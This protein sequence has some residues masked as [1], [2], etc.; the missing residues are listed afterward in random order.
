MKTLYVNRPWLPDRKELYA[1]FDDIL[2]T[3][4]LTNN[5][6]YVQL[7]EKKMVEFANV[8]YSY[9]TGNGTIALQIAIRALNIN[10]G[11]I[12]TTPHSFIASASSIVWQNCRPVFVDVEPD[13]LCINADLIKEKINTKT[14]AILAVHV[15]GS[16]CD[17]E[18]IN[19]IAAQH[20]LPVIYDASHAFGAAYKGESVFRFGT[21]S[22]A[23]LHA[24]KIVSAVE[25]GVVFCNEQQLAER[26]FKI[27]YFGKNEN[28]EE[29]IVGI[30]GKMDEFNA[31]FGVLSLDN[32]Q[33]ELE[34]RRKIASFYIQQLAS[35]DNVTLLSYKRNSAVNYSYFPLI[36]SGE[37]DLFRL[38]EAGKK[39][40]VLFKRIWYP[41]LNTL[42][43]L[44]APAA[45]L[46]VSDSISKRIVCVP[47]YSDMTKDDCQR[48]A[49]VVQ[50]VFT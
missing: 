28:N 27:R 41:S 19:R 35:L 8:P 40:Q 30:N 42:T 44:D 46:P 26:V 21:I 48:V 43:F 15:Y 39:Q 50:S 49:Q 37:E 33:Q 7:L 10:E 31:A 16:V 14:K 32:L 24:S 18:A 5:R 13:T 1:M 2:D 29:E 22:T 4:E 20:E 23:S 3:G 12:I 17:I 47:I 38:M 11:E 36:L 9:V 34:A 6:K 25:G 45:E